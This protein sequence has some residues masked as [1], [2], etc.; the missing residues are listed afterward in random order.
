M[1]HSR[2]LYNM[3]ST[4]SSQLPFPSY[5]LEKSQ[6]CAEQMLRSL[7]TNISFRTILSSVG[8]W[9]FRTMI[10]HQRPL[11]IMYDILS[12]TNWTLLTADMILLCSKNLYLIHDSHFLFHRKMCTL[13]QVRCH[14]PPIWLPALPSNLTYIL[15]VFLIVA[16]LNLPYPPNMNHEVTSE[17]N[18]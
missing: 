1:T 13:S 11:S 18:V 16:L 3:H 10:W 6:S 2:V 15:M 17:G 4:P 7:C 5:T 14:R 8:A 9:T 12:L